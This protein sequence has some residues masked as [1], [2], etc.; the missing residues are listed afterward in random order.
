MRVS[1]NQPL[2]WPPLHYF[3]RMLDVD[4]FVLLDSAQFTRSAR[5]RNTMSIKGRGGISTM[6]VPIVHT[7]KRER[8]IDLRVDNG[9]PWRQ[10]HYAA[11]RHSYGKT[12]AWKGKEGEFLKQLYY[13]VVPPQEHF[14]EIYEP[15]LDWAVEMIGGWGRTTRIRSSELDVKGNND[16]SGW[17]LDICKYFGA[18]EYLCGG[19]A[20]EYLDE[21][22]FRG[23][24]IKVVIQDWICLEYRQQGKGFWP[25]LSILDLIMNVPEENRGTLLKEGR[26]P[27]TQ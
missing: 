5:Y 14:R 2:Y 4:V 3:N 20:A 24:G 21:E 23:A 26:Q 22:A 6:T 1:I 19:R 25:N 15:A 13:G 8:I 7:G 10:K 9:Q 17:M 16:P 18:D 27:C 12:E 11:L